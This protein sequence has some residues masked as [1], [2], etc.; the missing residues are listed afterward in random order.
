MFAGVQR[1]RLRRRILR[2]AFR[3][4]A[5]R[6]IVRDGSNLAFP[7]GADAYSLQG[8]G[9]VGR[10]V[11]D[12]RALHRDPYRAPRSLGAQRSEHGIRA[13]E[14]LGAKSTADI[15][16]HHMDF[17]FRDAQRFRDVAHTPGDHLV[18]CP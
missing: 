3:K 2:A 8:G 7:C 11:R 13:H 14:Q 15:W 18:R 16:R 1:A 12:E 9:T 4:V 17:A 10:I 6:A 5:G